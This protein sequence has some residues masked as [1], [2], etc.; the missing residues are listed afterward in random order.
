MHAQFTL[1]MTV[2][3]EHQIVDEYNYVFNQISQLI[4]S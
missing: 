1:C 4:T 3:D 2:N